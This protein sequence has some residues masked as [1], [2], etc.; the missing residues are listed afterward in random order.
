[1]DNPAADLPGEVWRCVVGQ[2]D[3]YEVS[4]F[5]R[6]RTKPQ[7]L[8]AFAIPTGHLSINLGARRRTYVHRLVAEAFLAPDANRVLVNHKDG[9]PANNLV[10]N[11]EWCTPGENI[12]H[13]YRVNGRKAA[14]CRRIAAICPT[15]GEVLVEYASGVEASLAHPVSK[16][17]LYKAAK[18][19]NPCAGARWVWL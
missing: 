10:E 4:N 11:L 8:K 15:T 12:A 1:M 17:A 16:F 9:N 13:G 18:S 7:I 5:G 3:R 14:A 2:E 19:G 6:V